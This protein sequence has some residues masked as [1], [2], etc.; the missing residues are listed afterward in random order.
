M[1][2]SDLGFGR[3]FTA[4]KDINIATIPIGYA[5][6]FKK[7]FS[8]R[9]SAIIKGKMYSQIGNVSMDRIA[10]NLEN[11]KILKGEKVVLLGKGGKLQISLWDWADRLDTIP[12]EIACSIGARIPRIYKK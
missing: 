4:S 5:D 8:N 12:Y 2:S 11:D 6:G 9:F 7:G 1:C 3:G 10:F